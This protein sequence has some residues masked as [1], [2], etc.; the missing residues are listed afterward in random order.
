MMEILLLPKMI[1]L[2]PIEVVSMC[3]GLIGPEIVIGRVNELFVHI[4]RQKYFFEIWSF[5]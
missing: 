4:C 5:Q 1:I 2:D 3:E